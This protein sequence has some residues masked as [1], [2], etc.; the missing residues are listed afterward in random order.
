VLEVMMGKSVN[1]LHILVDARMADWS[2]V[3]RYSVGL[4]RALCKRDDLKVT[5]LVSQGA[6]EALEAKGSLRN[7][8][9]V[10]M[11]EHPFIPAGTREISAAYKESDAD[12]LHCL[13]YC[14]PAQALANRPIVVT[15]H[16]L[17][18]IVVTST[19]PNPLKR[20]IYTAKNRRALHVASQVIAPS[21]AT[22]TDIGKYFPRSDA[23]VS[24]IPE[25]ADD[26]GTHPLAVPNSNSPYLLSMGN[27][28]PHKNL[29]VL[30]EMMEKVQVD[31]P[32]LQLLL[33]G[34][35]DDRWLH[36]QQEKYSKAMKC[37]HFTG[38][39]SDEELRGY[40][41]HSQAF[42]CSS[43]Y[44]GFGLPPLE[45]AAF[46]VPVVIAR[47][48]SLPEVMEDASLTVDPHDSD[49][50]FSAVKCILD[51]KKYAQTLA[52]KARV[53]SLKFSWSQVADSTVD[54]YRKMLQS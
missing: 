22:A 11:R 43:Y 40:Y 47:A 21:Q 41:A 51:D 54:L 1:K 8:D 45:A 19:M 33:V 48:A 35:R 42:L 28:R 14:T 10:E 6:R 16:D 32:E 53:Q 29:E 3:G 31:Y 50:W 49:A 7:I 27:T 34:K 37:V 2:G 4:I 36:R 15:L 13:Q 44:E 24:V 5:A 20:Q 25:A 30:L 12:L 46:G 39:L 18:P 23:P 17:I 38:F 52:E 9:Y 26:F